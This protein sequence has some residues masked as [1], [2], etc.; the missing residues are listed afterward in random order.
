VQAALAL[1]AKPK[2]WRKLM[3]NGMARDFSWMVSAREYLKVY[4]KVRAA[5]HTEVV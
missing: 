2:E 3:L 4:D 1:Y 5:R